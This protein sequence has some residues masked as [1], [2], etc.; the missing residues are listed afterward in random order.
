[1]ALADRSPWAWPSAAIVFGAIGGAMWGNIYAAMIGILGGGVVGALAVA[2]SS[3][4]PGPPDEPTARAQQATARRAAA[5][6]RYQ[7]PREPFGP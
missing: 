2:A 5:G 4:D 1:V 6:S 3:I 7:H